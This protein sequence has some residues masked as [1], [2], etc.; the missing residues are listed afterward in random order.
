MSSAAKAL[1]ELRALTSK[2]VPTGDVLQALGTHARFAAAGGEHVSE[3]ADG[4][5][6]LERWECALAIQNWR[7]AA[8]AMVAALRKLDK[9]NEAPNV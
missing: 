2:P 5:H 1:A 9:E 4:K 8:N 7:A 3:A 6:A